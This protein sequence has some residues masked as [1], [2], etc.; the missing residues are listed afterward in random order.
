L[1]ANIFTPALRK[2]TFPLSRYRYSG[3]P[4][5][6]ALD[7]HF[8]SMT[9]AEFWNVP[10]P[11]DVVITTYDLA[12][13]RT[14]FVKPWKPSYK[15]WAV[16]KA[17]RASCTVPTY[18]PVVENR[19]IDGGVGSYGNPCYVAAYEARECLNWDPA[20]TTLISIGTGR[21]P[22]TFYTEKTPC[23]WAWDWIGLTLNAFQQSAYDQQVQLVRTHF[24]ELDFRRFQIDLQEN[25]EMDDIS[26]MDHLLAYGSRLGRM[27]VND[28]VDKAVV[29]P[30]NRL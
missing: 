22:H 30:L 26:K 8:G 7:K 4:L 2:W 27:I 3:E 25:I 10:T 5:A 28:Q 18:F 16:T 11:T 29:S 24:P 1:G 23:L 13:N 19:Y 9:M 21:A 14:R 12:E 6:A 17:V 20:E 15:D